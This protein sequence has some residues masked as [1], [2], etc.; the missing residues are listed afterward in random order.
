MEVEFLLLLSNLK[1]SDSTIA[2]QKF[3]KIFDFFLKKDYIP[4]INIVLFHR[5]DD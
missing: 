1:I 4:H 2:V 5:E 3:N